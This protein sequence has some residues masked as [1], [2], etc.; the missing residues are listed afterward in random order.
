MATTNLFANVK[1]TETSLFSS[2]LDIL[3]GFTVRD[4]RIIKDDRAEATQA[5]IKRSVNAA[6]RNSSLSQKVDDFLPNFDKIEALNKQIYK[7]II[8]GLLKLP[9]TGSA[10]S[11]AMDKVIAALKDLDGLE[12]ALEIPLRQQ[13]FT[14][15]EQQMPMTQAIDAIRPLI[16]G[17]TASGGQLAK[18]SRLVATDLLGAY[19]RY[20]EWAIAQANNLDGFYFTG[21][22]IDSSRPNCIDMVDGR[23]SF[24]TIAIKPALYAVKDIPRI[25]E[26]AKGG[27]GWRPET[28][29]ANW[30]W[31]LNG[32]NERHTLTF[33]PLT[34]S[35]KEALE[36]IKR[37]IDNLKAFKPEL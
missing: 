36:K 32:F 20:Q 17:T 33:V 29:V 31:L 19:G 10:K 8:P 12:T 13:L 30:P 7:E 23:G 14:A 34:K 2:I 22:L 15:V 5:K 16:K 27:A 26:V 37:V 24:S 35:D 3:R 4:G 28:T 18:Y 25:Y 21:S 11:L 6:L 9:P 1:K